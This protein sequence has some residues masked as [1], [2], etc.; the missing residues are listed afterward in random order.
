M[1]VTERQCEIVTITCGYYFFRF[2]W[3]YVVFIVWIIINILFIFVNSFSFFVFLEGRERQALFFFLVCFLG[4][5]IQNNALK[6]RL[7]QERVCVCVSVS[8]CKW[9]NNWAWMGLPH[10]VLNSKQSIPFQ[11]CEVRQKY[12][13]NAGSRII[14][15]ATTIKDIVMR[16]ITLHMLHPHHKICIFRFHF[17]W[18]LETDKK[19]YYNGYFSVPVF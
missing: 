15:S 16:S 12:L 13:W 18:D 5:G 14:R 7:E 17:Y 8:G 4:G 19:R 2:Y 10:F 11:V 1:R 3:V 9:W 6:Y